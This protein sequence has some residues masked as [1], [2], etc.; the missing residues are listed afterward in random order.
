MATFT[1]EETITD[2]I[3]TEVTNNHNYDMGG[4]LAQSFMTNIFTYTVP[5]GKYIKLIACY[6][7]EFNAPGTTSLDPSLVC[8]T[9][10]REHVLD[11]GETISFNHKT[12]FNSGNSLSTS[13]AKLRVEIRVFNKP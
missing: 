7:V 5:T 6:E 12:E 8:F 13:I 11:Q 3:T 9:Q 1:G 10:D 2:V 4:T